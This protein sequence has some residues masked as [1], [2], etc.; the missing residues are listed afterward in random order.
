MGYEYHMIPIEKKQLILFVGIQA[1]GKSSFY[2]AQFYD[3]HVRINRDMLKTKHREKTLFE[4]CLTI[5]QSMVLD[6]TNVT[7]LLRAPFI[8]KAK[9]ADFT[10]VGCYF[11]SKINEALARNAKRTGTQRIPDAGVRGTHAQ[12]E[13][14]KLSEGFDNLYYI[15]LTNDETDKGFNVSAWES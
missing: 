3:S 5:E 13:L 7:Q 9:E 6:N 12:L 1:T 15:K 14:P 4:T 11:E 2:K 8:A 10:V